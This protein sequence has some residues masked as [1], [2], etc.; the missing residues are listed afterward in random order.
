MIEPSTFS[1]DVLWYVV[2]AAVVIIP[3]LVA[4]IL[5]LRAGAGVASAVWALLDAIRRQIDEPAEQAT[6][7]AA[8]H[9]APEDVAMLEALIKRVEDALIKP[10]Q[11]VNLAEPQGW[12][13]TST[14]TYAPAPTTNTAQDVT[15]EILAELEP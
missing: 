1:Q 13:A 7:S 10:A 4:L 14:I 6:V 12:Q 15:A 11:E 3:A 2:S 5:A 9:I 8:L